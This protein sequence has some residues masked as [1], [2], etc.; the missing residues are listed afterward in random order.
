MSLRTASVEA[1]TLYI[2]EQRI[3][4]VAHYSGNRNILTFD[5]EYAAL[6]E[7]ERPVFTLAQKM[8]STYLQSP[9]GSTLR[10]PPVL[11]N[12]LPEGTLREWM[13]QALKIHRD[14]EFPLL[15]YTAKNLPGALSARAVALG[16]LPDWVKASREGRLEPVQIDV[17]QRADKF[18][19]AG[20]Q[21]KFSAL[22]EGGRFNVSTEVGEDSWI[23][24]TPSVVH[25]FL[26]E[27]EFTAMTLAASVGIDVPE[28]K[29]VGLS[30]IE[31][32]PDIRLPDEPFAFSIKRFDRG[33]S[34]R[35]HTEDFA[36]IFEVYAHD[37]YVRHNYEQIAVL[38]ARVASAGLSDVQQM[39]RRLL[40][41]ILLGN[42]DAHLK[43]WS[44]I[45][46]D[47]LNARLSPAYDIVSTRMYMQDEDGV[48]LNMAKE[49][50]WAVIDFSTFEKWANR[51]GVSW[52]A[53][54][55]HLNDVLNIARKEWSDRLDSLPMADAH[56]VIL[57]RHW[58]SLST[59][60]RL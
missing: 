22:M 51:I 35:I 59:D 60:F 37:K 20:V 38:L 36:Q 49:K 9:L 58:A 8:R 50:R 44:V 33:V 30:A 54:K 48:A 42:G 24:K 10:L 11:S 52:P 15:A 13:A 45:Y 3:G 21:M 28:I 53:I 6:A 41:N 25:P 17:R 46:P 7:S 19:L 57:R 16:E 14:S 1:L 47:G 18:S 29:L 55:V 31:N 34:G 39:A 2:H 40:V 12:L 56:K 26:A 5:P 23:I 43:N 32:L 27:N 4:V